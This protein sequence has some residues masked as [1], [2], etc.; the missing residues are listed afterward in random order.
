[1]DADL[2]FPSIHLS[3]NKLCKWPPHCFVNIVLLFSLTYVL[4]LFLLSPVYQLLSF[5]KTMVTCTS[6]VANTCCV[7]FFALSP[8]CFS[9]SSLLSLAT[10]SLSSILKAAPSMTENTEHNVSLSVEIW[11]LPGLW[12]G[13]RQIA[14]VSVAQII[15]SH[16]PTS[17]SGYRFSYEL[18]TPDTVLTLSYGRVSGHATGSA[19]MVMWQNVTQ[20]TKARLQ[21]KWNKTKKLKE[22][23]TVLLQTCFYLFYFF[24]ENIL[25]FESVK[26]PP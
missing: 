6:K 10:L 14:L 17:G 19:A 22:K 1:M 18:T 26:E 11:T 15:L 7:K 9:C 21:G 25:P 24:Y 13:T 8:C 23:M 2:L 4:F 12:K 3:M 16:G 20:L 5:C